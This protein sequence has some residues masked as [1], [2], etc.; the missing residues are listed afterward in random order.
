[1]KP[2]RKNVAIA[3]DGGGIRGVIVTKALSILE[4]ELGRPLHEVFRLTAGT[5][6][7]SIIAAGLATGMT[8]AQ[9][10]EMYLQL[11]GNVF[12]KSL[13]TALWYLFNHRYAAGPLERAL[14]TY[15]GDR[16]VGDLWKAEPPTDVVLTTFDVVENR[17]RFIKSYK[18][19][20]ETWPLYKAVLAS[21]AAP[22]YFPAV[23]GEFI[24]GGVGSYN[25][26]CYLAAYEIQY[27]LP[28]KP[29]ETTLISI[30]TGR[31]K[32]HIHK[33]AVDHFLPPQYIGPLIDAFTHCAADQQVD[34]VTKLFPGLDFRR[35]Q[36][37]LQQ[38]IP[39]DDT[40]MLQQMIRYGDQ[41]GEMILTDQTDGSMRIVAT[42]APPDAARRLIPTG[43]A[44]RSR[45]SRTGTPPASRPRKSARSS[46]ARQR[47]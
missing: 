37:D 16:T 30:G 2:F 43:S 20:Y 4:D 13:R 28:W 47:R 45:T 10:F 42:P 33:G 27:G 38:P 14:R 41:L 7:G 35:F 32:G 24:D 18:S 36:V 1:M 5:S 12:R 9:L 22:T 11:S 3:I 8:A 25:N 6:T 26:P 46:R 23:D 40:S 21:A 44:S 31:E 17:T 19:E 15:F 34:L 39:L 29:Q